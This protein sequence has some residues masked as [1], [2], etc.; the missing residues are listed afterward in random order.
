MTDNAQDSVPAGMLKFS[1]VESL[2]DFVSHESLDQI[3]AGLSCDDPINI[4]FTSGTTGL[5]KGATL[6][7]SNIV[8]TLPLLYVC[9][10]TKLRCKQYHN[11]RSSVFDKFHLDD[12]IVPI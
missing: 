3:S 8:K 9:I 10:T 6:S 12:L 1:E 11:T 2:A 7:H 4:Q 5:P